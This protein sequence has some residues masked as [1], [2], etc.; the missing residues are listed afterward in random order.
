MQMRSN[1]IESS[2]RM[3]DS[4]HIRAASVMEAAAHDEQR[5][6]RKNPKSHKKEKLIP[7]SSTVMQFFGDGTI[8]LVQG[9]RADIVQQRIPTKRRF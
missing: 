5:L 9:D 1:S 6:V 7:V 8:P 2:Q 3:N 4:G